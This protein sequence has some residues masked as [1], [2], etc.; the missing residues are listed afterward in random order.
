MGAYTLFA[1][2]YFELTRLP[3]QFN[4]I[5][6][7][8]LDAIEQDDKLIF[9]YTVKE[10][11]ANKSYGLQVALLAGVPKNVVNQ[12]RVHLKQLE[13]QQWRITSPQT[14]L[15]L[16]SPAP[17][18]PPN[19]PHPVIEKLKTLSPEDLTPRQALEIIYQLKAL[20]EETA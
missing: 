20:A 19:V 7:I 5:Q 12:A 1:T 13:E 17:A 10:G 18:P 6:N 11:P 16:S 4:T 3:E 8:H 14:E 2:H 15:S 9:M